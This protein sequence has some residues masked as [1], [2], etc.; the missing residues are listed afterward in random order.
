MFKKY[1]RENVIYTDGKGLQIRGELLSIHS[2]K[3]NMH[4]SQTITDGE[5]CEN[6]SKPCNVR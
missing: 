2:D 4:I 1:C 3:E 5:K 6:D